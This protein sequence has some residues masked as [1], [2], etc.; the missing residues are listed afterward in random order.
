[1]GT[2]HAEMEMA[3]NSSS[4][5]QAAYGISAVVNAP[6]DEAV[7]RTTA[8]LKEEGF[9]VLTTIDVRKTL[10][11][12]IDVDFEPYVILGACNPNLAHRA[13]QAEHE[14]GLLLPCNVIVHEH[15]GQ[16][17]VSILD[18]DQMLT[19]AG[20][21]ADLRAVAAEAGERLRRVSSKLSG[22]P[23]S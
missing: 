5:S 3:S 9:G 20:D 22:A 6:L 19:I 7:E 16:S 23:A 14:V 18:P 8:A 12:K 1:M 2:M 15:D 11:D 13:L 21:N 4:Q 17:V 10:K